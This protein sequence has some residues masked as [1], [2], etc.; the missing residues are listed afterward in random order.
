MTLSNPEKDKLQL[1]LEDLQDLYGFTYAEFLRVL[2]YG[3]QI[4]GIEKNT[5]PISKITT[6]VSVRLSGTVHP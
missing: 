1:R 6:E 5:G 2:D 3:A 4:V